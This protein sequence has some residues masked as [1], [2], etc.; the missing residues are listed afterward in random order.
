MRLGDNEWT[1]DT[2]N[3]IKKNRNRGLKLLIPLIGYIISFILISNEHIILAITILFTGIIAPLL[4]PKRIKLAISDL[5]ALDL[6]KIFINIEK[7][8]GRNP[9]FKEETKKALISLEIHID[10]YLQ[11]KKRAE[12][13]DFNEEKNKTY[14]K[15]LQKNIKKIYCFFEEYDKYKEKQEELKQICQNLANL[16]HENEDFPENAYSLI[17]Q[18]DNIHISEKPIRFELRQFIKNSLENKIIL[19]IIIFLIA[20][21]LIVWYLPKFTTLELSKEKST[22]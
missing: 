11:E 5:I 22:T 17:N 18:L 8:N 14:L 6:Y 16:F 10:K 2:I 4:L 13:L 20:F 19:Q 21:P 15:K 1:E 7:F 12:I 9:H 3:I